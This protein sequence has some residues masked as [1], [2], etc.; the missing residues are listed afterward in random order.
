MTMMNDDNDEFKLTITCMDL[1]QSVP[2]WY[3]LIT[4]KCMKSN[5]RSPV[6]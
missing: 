5:W 2:D 3:K 6:S 4:M 1:Y